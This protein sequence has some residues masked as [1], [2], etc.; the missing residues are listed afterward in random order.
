MTLE[1]LAKTLRD[2]TA[3]QYET[4]QEFQTSIRASEAKTLSK[5]EDME[6]KSIDRYDELQ[7]KMDSNLERLCELI[8]RKDLKSVEVSDSSPPPYRHPSYQ[9]PNLNS[10]P[11][12]SSRMEEGN[13]R[14]TGVDGR[15]SLLKRIT[16][17]SFNGE[18][19]YGWFALAERYFRIGGYDE[20]KNW[21]FW[22]NS[23]VQRSNFTSWQDFKDRVI[24]RFSRERLRDPSQPFFAVRQTG[25]IAQYIHKFEDLSTQVSGLTDRQR[26][27]V[28]MN[29]LTPEMR[30]VVNMSKPVDLPE[31]IATA[32]QLED[33][34]L[35]KMVCRER[36]Y[37]AK[38]HQ[39][40]TFVKPTSMGS[41]LDK[42]GSSKAQKPQL[43]LTESQI[44]EKKKLGLC[45]TCDEKWSR[46]NWC[47]NRS[48]QVLTL[49]NGMEIEIVDQSL[50]E[51]QLYML[52]W[53]P[54]KR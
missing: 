32:Y 53:C 9:V 35:Y 43:R 28:F 3:V 42:S 54:S 47:P 40:Q 38:Q 34:S 17:P 37:E 12:R 44:A 26:E 18:D 8:T 41:A 25:K 21:R 31:M 20:R 52:R 48:L 30:E 24:A 14:N 45:F 36:N 13:E 2:H 11:G 51:I 4:N 19:S 22:F 6:K 27:G 5:I 23:E 39:R 1:S 10:E 49:V 50:V 33:S 16:L 29:G 15:D 46:Q 7:A